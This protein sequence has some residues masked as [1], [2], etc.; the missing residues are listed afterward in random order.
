MQMLTQYE[1][2][3]ISF[4]LKLKRGVREIGRVLHRDP[5]VV[6][7][8]INRNSLPDGTYD[9]MRAQKKADLRSR[10]TNTRKLESD[11]R[12]H[13]W[14]EKKLKAG[15]S[16]E[17]IAGRLKQCPPTHPHGASVSH[18]QIY[19][20]IYHGEGKYEGWFHYLLR[21]SH[22]RRTKRSRKKQAKTR[23]K[24]RVAI[25]ERPLVA[26]ERGRFGDWESDLAV[27]RKQKTALSVQYER[28]AMIIRMHKVANRTARENNQAISRTLET[29]PAYLNKSITFD[30]GLENTCH[31]RI[32]DNFNVD[33]YFCRPYAAWQKGGVEN[34]IG[35]I[36]RYLPKTTNLAT[37]T[38]EDIHAIQEIL[39][40]RP[41]KKLKYKTPNEALSV[42]LNS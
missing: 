39:N 26:N 10:K 41:R 3:K 34:A 38:D 20:Y 9:P 17:L 18:E 14:V 23:I 6:S 32:R 22:S 36:R 2:E 12:L 37:L 42:A 16:P 40:N 31:T 30:N 19:Q 35:L 4:S 11:W 21:K 1:R 7:R 33:T 8:E 5:G 15:W 27:Y 29:M 25:T 28:Q 13:D 24:E